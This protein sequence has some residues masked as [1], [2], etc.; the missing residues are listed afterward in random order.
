MSALSSGNDA[1]AFRLR[2][3]GGGKDLADAGPVHAN[4]LFREDVFA[5]LHGGGDVQRPEARRGGQDH[6]V[7]AGVDHVQVGIQ[8]EEATALRQVDQVAAL[9]HPVFVIE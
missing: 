3:L 1:Q 2:F 4:R 5:R 6:E 9:F 8:T 7:H